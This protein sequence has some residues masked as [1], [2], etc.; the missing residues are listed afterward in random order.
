MKQ[1]GSRPGILY[2]L[3][4]IHKPLVNGHS[5]FRPVLFAI[6]I[7]IYRI[8]KFIVPIMSEITTNE[9]TIQ[10]SFKFGQEIIHQD[11]SLFM[12]SLDVD[13]LFMSIPLD[14]SI[15]ICADN[16]FR[17]QD[18]IAKLNKSEVKELLSAA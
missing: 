17:D 3:A 14:E 2:G 13:S 7:A 4:K 15:N 9:Y 10:K 5:K 8:A 6:E 1:I 12:G 11:S 16:L 18:V